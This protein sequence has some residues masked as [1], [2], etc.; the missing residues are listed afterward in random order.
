LRYY[1][2][3]PLDQGI[4]CHENAII[5]NSVDSSR[6]WEGIKIDKGEEVEIKFQTLINCE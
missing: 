3:D 4:I 5:M 6:N 1:A 2:I